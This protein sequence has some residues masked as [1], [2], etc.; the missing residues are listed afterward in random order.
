MGGR[1]GTPWTRRQSM[2]GQHTMH[3]LIHTPKGNLERPINLTGMSLDCGRKP[4]YPERTQ[5]CT[6]RTCELHAERPR[7]GVE[8][9]TY[10]LQ[11]NSA[12][13]QPPVKQSSESLSFVLSERYEACTN[14]SF[15]AICDAQSG[16]CVCPLECVESHQPVC[17]SDGNTYNSECEL[18]V[19]SCIKQMELRVVS[20]GECK[21]CG[22]TIC[23]WGARCVDKK[24]ECPQCTGE[25]NSPVCGSDGITY[26]NEC[27]LHSSSC[28]Q[29]R[30]IDVAKPGSCEE[31]C[32]SG[33]SGS[34]VESCEQ[35]RCT[36]HGGLWAED[37]EDE[38]CICSFNCESV[39]HN[40]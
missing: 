16:Q 9:R 12:P 25:A 29:K 34:G 10:L 15:G 37:E 22:N 35:E 38:R 36:M 40:Q 33:A 13:V 14:C 26:D 28:I 6:E 17:G 18:N 21:T 32:G 39:P 24:C 7:P 19:R 11:G 27:E 1:Q 8:P 31:E 20:Q 5:E 3:T 30:K 4:E 2:A 23:S